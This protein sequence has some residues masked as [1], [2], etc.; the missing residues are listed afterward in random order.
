MSYQEGMQIGNMGMNLARTFM[1]VNQEQGR[2]EDRETNKK[3]YELAGILANQQAGGKGMQQA[4]GR[5]SGTAGMPNAAVMPAA[6]KPP[7]RADYDPEVWFKGNSLYQ[8]KQLNDFTIK[9]KE[10]VLS[11]EGRK[12]EA[13]KVKQRVMQTND[14][15]KQYQ[16]LLKSGGDKFERAIIASKIDNRLPN[17][18]ASEIIHGKD[19]KLQVKITNFSGKSEIVDLNEENIDA[20]LAQFDKMAAS[21]FGETPQKQFA[22]MASDNEIRREHNKGVLYA[23]FSNKDAFYEAKDGTDWYLVGAKDRLY[24]P[25]TGK[26]MQP[27][28]TKGINDSDRIPVGSEEAKKLGLK[29]LPEKARKV[30]GEKAGLERRGKM[31]DVEKKEAD[32]KRVKEGRKTKKDQIAMNKSMYTAVEKGIKT[33]RETYGSDV[34]EE[35]IMLEENRLRADYKS[36]VDP[37]YQPDPKS[38]EMVRKLVVNKPGP[39]EGQTVYFNAAGKA[40]LDRQGKKPLMGGEQEDNRS[41]RNPDGS[42]RRFQINSR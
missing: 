41:S 25:E 24:N 39:Y 40:F 20:M 2:Q 17:G 27:F 11:A 30:A 32:A 18:R 26:I 5:M 14:D 34:S 42:L 8:Q 38:K 33:Y 31:A 23:A 36:R 16:T 15:F 1:M 13:G 9:Q 10:Y 35:G 21:H 6:S 19:G 28:F 4:E 37:D 29:P 12:D 7:N 22:L 3:A